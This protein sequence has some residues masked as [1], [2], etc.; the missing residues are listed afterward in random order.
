MLAD[1]LQG[2]FLIICSNP[3]WKLKSNIQFTSS[4]L[5]TNYTSVQFCGSWVLRESP[6]EPYLKSATF[7]VTSFEVKK[8][9]WGSRTFAFV[10]L[11][12]EF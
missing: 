5:I 3:F 12:K 2:T 7:G 4:K 9:Y 11:K 8:N 1:S 6:H 10:P